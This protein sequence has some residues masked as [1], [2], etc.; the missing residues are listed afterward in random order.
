[1]VMFEIQCKVTWHTSSADFRRS[2]D[3]VRITNRSLITRPTVFNC[4]ILLNAP[5]IAECKV[6]NENN[7][8]AIRYLQRYGFLNEKMDTFATSEDQLVLRHAI[9]LFQEYYRLPVTGKVDNATLSLMRKPRCGLRDILNFGEG[10]VIRMWPKRYLT[11]N[12]HL[13]N[14]ALLNTT[15]AAFDLWQK[16]SSLTFERDVENPNILISWRE[17]RHMFLDHRNG[18]LCSSVLDGPGGT[19]AHSIP[20]ERRISRRRFTSTHTQDGTVAYISSIHL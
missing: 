9:N 8:V 15:Q 11:W 10:K 3:T 13:A 2:A 7:E 14:R 18:E 20:M 19:L 12:F 5:I 16:H 6:I 17:G 1:M 4:Y